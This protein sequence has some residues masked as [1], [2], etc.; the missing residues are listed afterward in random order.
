MKER[1]YKLCCWNEG[2]TFVRTVV[3]FITLAPKNTDNI[4]FKKKELKLKLLVL[5]GGIDVCCETFVASKPGNQRFLSILHS[6][7]I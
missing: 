1:R 5:I 7:I 2:E 3:V 6:H 4:M